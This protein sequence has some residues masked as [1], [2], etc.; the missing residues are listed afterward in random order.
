MLILLLRNKVNR[1]NYYG[2]VD[3]HEDVDA[4]MYTAKI[5]SDL[6]ENVKLTN[7]TRLGKTSMNRVLTGI[8]TGSASLE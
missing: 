3:D 1:E 7:I 5:E 8:N 2:H 6:A 4:D